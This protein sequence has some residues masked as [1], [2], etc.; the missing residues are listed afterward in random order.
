ML[1]CDQHPGQRNTRLQ[2]SK[3]SPLC[4]FWAFN[5]PQREPVY[6]PLI[7]SLL[8]CWLLKFTQI[9]SQFVLKCVWFHSF[10]IARFIHVII[11]SS[12]SFSSLYIFTALTWINIK[13]L[14]YSFYC[15]W[16]LGLFP[17][18]CR[19]QKLLQWTSAYVLWCT[20]FPFLWGSV[21]KG[22][23]L[24]PMCPAMPKCLPWGWEWTR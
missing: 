11:Y 16:K 24:G 1:L 2:E 13:Q 17:G 12:G 7:P 6:E 9:G 8:L 5:P 14:M 18:F 19:W 10:P 20:V 21:L 3:Q 4:H 22:E 23:P 15:G